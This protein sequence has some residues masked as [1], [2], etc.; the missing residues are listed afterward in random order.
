[1]N[2]RQTLNSF[3]TEMDCWVQKREELSHKADEMKVQ[4][5]AL[6]QATEVRY[7]SLFIHLSVHLFIHSFI[8]PSIH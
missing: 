4:R 5:D 1:M 2:R 6:L 8:H 3:D 7:D